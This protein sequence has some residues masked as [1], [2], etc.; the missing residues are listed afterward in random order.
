MDKTVAKIIDYSKILYKMTDDQI[1][2]MTRQ[3]S[4]LSNDEKK[5]TLIS[6]YKSYLMYKKATNDLLL[7]ISTVNN[8][9]EEYKEHL[10]ADDILGQIDNI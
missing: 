3:L 2:N 1:V 4:N 9:M 8:D 6:F 10:E 5:E 7:K